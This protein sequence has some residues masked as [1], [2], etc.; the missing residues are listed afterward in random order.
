MDLTF[1]DHNFGTFEWLFSYEVYYKFRTFVRLTFLNKAKIQIYR[2]TSI[3]RLL[4]LNAPSNKRPT[5]PK[6]EKFN[7][8]PGRLIEVIR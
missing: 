4:L 7:K 5:P 1:R 6:I 3:K 8:R 2:I